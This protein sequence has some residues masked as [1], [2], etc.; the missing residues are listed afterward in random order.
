MRFLVQ[1]TAGDYTWE[2]W[3]AVWELE[4]ISRYFNLM[5]VTHWRLLPKS[6]KEEQA[7]A[8]TTRDATAP[9]GHKTQEDRGDG[10]GP[11]DI[12]GRAGTAPDLMIA[13]PATE[14]ELGQGKR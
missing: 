9:P 11:G 1:W 6:D 4:A 7:P 10:Q 5:G 3:T 13:A 12:T 8:R 14:H 2:P